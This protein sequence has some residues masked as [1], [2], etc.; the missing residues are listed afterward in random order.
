MNVGFLVSLA[1]SE[2]RL[3]FLQLAPWRCI[4]S[5]ASLAAT[6]SLVHASRLKKQLDTWG[7]GWS[8]Q[9]MT[10]QLP[11]NVGRRQ[12]DSRAK[13]D[14]HHETVALAAEV[15]TVLSRYLSKNRSIRKEN[16]QTNRP[17]RCSSRTKHVQKREI[18]DFK[19]VSHPT[20]KQ[21]SEMFEEIRK[22]RKNERQ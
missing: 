1:S 5:Q 17:S 2:I 14:T 9:Q 21:R 6:V 18:K 20:R 15:V 3:A 4:V 16:K 7:K 13:R 10:R 19:S 22:E 11:Y 8:T 12:R